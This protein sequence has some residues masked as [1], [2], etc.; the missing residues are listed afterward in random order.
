M[1]SLR[2]R[3]AYGYVPPCGILLQHDK[4]LDFTSLQYTSINKQIL[5]FP[6][7]SGGKL[8]IL[9]KG[10]LIL[11]IITVIALELN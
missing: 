7:L 9:Q 3:S 2:Q 1:P 10:F 4:S 6:I 11:S 5:M 8:S